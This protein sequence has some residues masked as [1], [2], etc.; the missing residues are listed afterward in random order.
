VVPRGLVPRQHFGAG[1][2]ALA[3][4]LFG[5]L[6][7]SAAEAARRAG[8]WA[9]GASAWR[10]VRRWLAAIEQRRLFAVV[11]GAPPS[12]SPRRCAARAAM[13][14]ASLVPAPFAASDAARAFAGAALAS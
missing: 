2:I 6:G 3:L 10:T 11:R 4:F 7:Q 1:A 14:L 5:V 12:W 8:S 9:A 13:T